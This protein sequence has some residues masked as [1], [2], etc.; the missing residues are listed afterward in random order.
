M[1][2]SAQPLERI[3][4][5]VVAGVLVIGCFVVIQP[6]LS[7]ILWALILALATW[8]IFKWLE[9]RLG[10]HRTLAA[11]LLTLFY[12][13]LIVTPT[14]LVA[15]SL[16]DNVK[17]AYESVRVVL[18]EGL[19]APP[20]WVGKIPL[21]GA[22]LHD[23]WLA[24][25]GSRPALLAVLRQAAA[26]G[27]DNLL[28]MTAYTGQ[29][30]FFMILSILLTFFVYRDGEA[31]FVRIQTAVAKVGGDQS[32]RLLFVA[33]DTLR[34][35]VYGIIGTGLA[36]GILAGIGFLL[37][38][39][40]YPGLLGLA[41]FFLSPIPVG[42]PLIWGTAALR[43]FLAGSTGK[44]V[45]MLIWGF[46]VVSGIDNILKPYLI[47]RGSRMPLALIL[48]G[49]MG[50]ALAFGI[51]GVFLGP[52]LLAVAS[53]VFV[54]WSEGAQVQSDTDGEPVRV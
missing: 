37:A 22:W 48:L 3:A 33:G 45:F 36:Q 12:L 18:E 20:A 16:S 27:R 49:V 38:G 31:F 23:H 41:T 10:G 39:V 44:A 24:V 8:P 5:I 35:V 6:F 21:A 29:A 9:R 52:A 4:L 15:W 13:A 32:R 30:L 17:D 54:Q 40:R 42:P 11:L 26:F 2:K 19:P 51:L 28:H 1:A 46:L 50:G 34:S 7:A 25:A 47:S 14:A 43:L 53:T